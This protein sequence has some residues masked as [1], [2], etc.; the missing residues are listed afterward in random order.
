MM[1]IK[2]GERQEGQGKIKE[3][4]GGEERGE[5]IEERRAG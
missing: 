5:R 2:R 4:K 3:D 1:T